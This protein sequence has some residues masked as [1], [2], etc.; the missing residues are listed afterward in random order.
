MISDPGPERSKPHRTRIVSY[1]SASAIYIERFRVTSQVQNSAAKW[2]YSTRVLR[3]FLSRPLVGIKC[4]TV[5]GAFSALA[6]AKQIVTLSK[7]RLSY[8]M[9]GTIVC[10]S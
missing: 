4:I 3:K 7:N 9:Y 10:Y 2:K 6:M 5:Y 1:T 8:I